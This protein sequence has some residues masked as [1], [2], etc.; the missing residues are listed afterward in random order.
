[1]DITEFLRIAHD[2]LMSGVEVSEWVDLTDPDGTPILDADGEPLVRDVIVF[3]YGRVYVERDDNDPQ[4]VQ[5]FIDFLAALD[6]H[7]PDIVDL[8]SQASRRR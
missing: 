4:A 3:G 8:L 1:M 2:L 5:D 6:E 7:L